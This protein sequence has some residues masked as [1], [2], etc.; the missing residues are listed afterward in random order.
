MGGNRLSRSPRI[1]IAPA[2][3]GEGGGEVGVMWSYISRMR[4]LPVA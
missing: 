1:G 3:I 4:V 2:A